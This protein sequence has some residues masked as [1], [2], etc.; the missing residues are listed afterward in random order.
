[1]KGCLWQDTAL[2]DLSST[3]VWTTR[4]W[5][6]FGLPRKIFLRF[7]RDPVSSGA[8]FLIFALKASFLLGILAEGQCDL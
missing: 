3:V 1:M 4:D 7:F 5:E 6:N 2:L 8:T